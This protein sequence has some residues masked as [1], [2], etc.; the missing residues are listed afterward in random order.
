MKK[1]TRVLALV[2]CLAASLWGWQLVLALSVP[3]STPTVSEL[4]ANRNLIT[5][6]DILIYGESDLPAGTPPATGASD[7]IIFKLIASDNLTELGA[8]TPYNFFDNGWN[9]G[10]FGFYFSNMT[11][12][13]VTW[14]TSYTIRIAENPAQYASPTY[15][16]YVF[17]ASGYSTASSNQTAQQTELA[18]NIINAANRLEQIF[19]SYTLLD[20]GASGTVLSSPSGETYFRGAIYGIQAMAPDLFM[21]QVLTYDASG[22]SMTTAYADNMTSQFAATWVGASENAT[23]TQFGLTKQSAFGIIPFA[24]CAGAVMLSMM[25]WR[26][27]EPGFVAGALFMIW[28][29]LVGWLAPAIFAAVFQLMAIYNGYLLFLARA[30]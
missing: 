19:T 13:N 12:A 3:D 10:V 18:I 20:T 8:V 4:H 27:A 17:P 11:T 28:G 30:S 16:D 6:G 23:V 9:E 2:F 1:A 29:L 26:K 24:L 25:K 22:R 21:I 7:A 5:T 14:G 15:W